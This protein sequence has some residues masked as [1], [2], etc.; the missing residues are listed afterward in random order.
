MAYSAIQSHLSKTLNKIVYFLKMLMCF[1]PII[2]IGVILSEQRHGIYMEVITFEMLIHPFYYLNKNELPNF[3]YV[4]RND[5]F[6]ILKPRINEKNLKYF[7]QHR[8]LQIDY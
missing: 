7:L 3:L 6:K 1:M 4:R 2:M 8:I 5:K